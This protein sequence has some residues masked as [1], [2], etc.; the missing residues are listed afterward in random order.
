MWLVMA[1]NL[2]SSG[3]ISTYVQFNGFIF[4][5]RQHS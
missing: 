2:A 1:N 4:T 5:A 3:G